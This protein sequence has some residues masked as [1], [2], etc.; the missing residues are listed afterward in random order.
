MPCLLNIE[1]VMNYVI[2]SMKYFKTDHFIVNQTLL[3]VMLRIDDLWCLC[4]LTRL[5]VVIMLK[6]GLYLPKILFLAHTVC[7]KYK[8]IVQIYHYV[9]YFI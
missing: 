9:D 8:N 3:V 4:L 2:I 1:L 5:D 7:G 6:F